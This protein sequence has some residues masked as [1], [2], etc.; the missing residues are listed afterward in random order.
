MKIKTLI[1]IVLILII[2]SI[3][4]PSLISSNPDLKKSTALSIADFGLENKKYEW[5]LSACDWMLEDSPYDSEILKRKVAVLT[6][7]EDYEGALENQRII[8]EL[9]PLDMTKE[10]WHNLA[11]LNARTN[12][13]KDSVDSYEQVL[14]SCELML[15]TSPDDSSAIMEKADVLIKLQRYDEAIEAYNVVINEEPS[16]AGA[17]IGLGD[18]YLFKSMYLQGQL[19]DMYKELGRA[20]SGEK[21]G[22]DMSSFES[23]R[24]A[25]ESYNKAVEIDP[26][27]YPMVAAKIM[28]G[29]EKTVSGYQDILKNL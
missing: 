27:S 1:Y 3:A 4:V 23:H 8:Q 13:T 5:S 20:P 16:N 2:L 25:V 18:A 14:K 24:K 28:G 10:D 15:K 17:W 12:N 26:L 7:L 29:F 19:K 11:V 22:Y 6:I 9:S 21:T